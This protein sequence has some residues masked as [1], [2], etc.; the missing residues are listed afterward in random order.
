MSRWTPDIDSQT[1]AFTTFMQ[2]VGMGF[3]FVPSNIFAFA[4][5]P[6][7][8]RTDGASIINLVRNV[9]SAIGVS[10]TSTVLTSMTQIM[11]AQLSAHASPYNRALG[12][13]A[14]SLMLNPQIPLGAGMQ[15]TIAAYADVFLLMFYI[16]LP[17]LVLILCLP[18]TQLLP[19]AAPPS[20][21]EAVE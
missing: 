16:S 12:V 15:A 9:G 21:M 11:Y 18:K 14:P 17:I 19:R 13:N 5:L 2:G 7:Q 1:L 4:T 6:Q 20:E 10:V 8:L 3:I